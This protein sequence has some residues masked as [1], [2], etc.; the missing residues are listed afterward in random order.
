VGAGSLWTDLSVLC[1]LKI[2]LIETVAIFYL[3][4]NRQVANY[5]F[6]CEKSGDFWSLPSPELL[7]Q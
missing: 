5:F 1:L 7:S 4:K 2:C 6:V 3:A